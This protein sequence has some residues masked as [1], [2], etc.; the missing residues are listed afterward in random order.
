MA[1][2]QRGRGDERA[3]VP[4]RPEDAVLAA[5]R[6][7]RGLAAPPPQ[8]GAAPAMAAIQNA[9]RASQDARSAADEIARR[10]GFRSEQTRE[11]TVQQLTE[12]RERLVRLGGVSVGTP[13]ED[14]KHQEFLQP[15]IQSLD[16]LIGALSSGRTARLS[17]E[18]ANSVQ[19]ATR[20]VQ[21][22]M[23]I[24]NGVIRGHRIRHQAGG[25]AE[26]GQIF[27][28]ALAM[29]RRGETERARFVVDDMAAQYERRARFMN[30]RE[31]ASDLESFMGLARRTGNLGTRMSAEDLNGARTELTQIMSQTDLHFAQSLENVMRAVEAQRVVLQQLIA[32]E[33]SEGVRDQ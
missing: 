1:Q 8:T 29:H 17:D 4:M 28:N 9:E 14:Q 19:S 16:T 3:A 18:D 7:V 27:E 10:L 30:S 15:L 26:L 31:G 12:R 5:E 21:A 24:L 22:D 11:Q 2:A 33:A 25:P 32:R 23:H 6:Y 13:Q 20:A